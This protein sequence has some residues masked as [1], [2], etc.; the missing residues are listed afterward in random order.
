[1]KNIYKLFIIIGLIG[2]FANDAAAQRKRNTRSREPKEEKEPLA[3]PWMAIHLGNVGFG[4]GFSISGKYSY[5]YEFEKR[6][7]IG[8]NGKFYYDFIN[9]FGFVPDANLFSYGFG[10]FSRIKI[11]QDIFLQGEYTYTSFDYVNQPNQNILYPSVG[12]GYKSG[13][14][15]W[16][17]GLHILF[18]LNQEARN[19]LNLEY[20]ID[21]NY[22]F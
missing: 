1:M 11:T 2:L 9:N 8:A 6:F 10:A 18:P 21:F 13:V 5:A 19:I 7:S 12:A 4:N 17:Y 20:W 16:S 22:K 14:D 3:T 15:N